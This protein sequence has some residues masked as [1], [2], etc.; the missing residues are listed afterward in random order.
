MEIW[1]M[2][3]TPSVRRRVDQQ[4]QRDQQQQYQQWQRDQQQQYQQWQRDQQQLHEDEKEEEAKDAEDLLQEV[5]STQQN[6]LQ[7]FYYLPQSQEVRIAGGGFGPHLLK[8]GATR[9]LNHR[10]IPTRHHRSQ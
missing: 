4:R 7:V 10:K 3:A 1:V 2:S 5:F 6:N 8:E 9:V